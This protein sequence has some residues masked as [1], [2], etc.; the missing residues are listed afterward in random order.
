M[1]V[2]AVAALDYSAVTVAGQARLAP[3]I[4]FEGTAMPGFV[5]W[6]LLVLVCWPM[7]L[8]ALVL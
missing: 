1:A 2:A 6:L 3:H 8:M 7:A 5:L 4:L